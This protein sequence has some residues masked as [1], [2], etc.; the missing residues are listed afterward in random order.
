V[1]T[2][3]ASVDGTAA[4]FMVTLVVAVGLAIIPLLRASTIDLRLPGMTT[5]LV[6]T[7]F[8]TLTLLVLTHTSDLMLGSLPT[9]PLDLIRAVVIVSVPAAVAVA[10][11]MLATGRRR[12]GTTA[13]GSGV[14]ALSAGVLGLADVV[15]PIELV[16]VPLAL[17]LLAIGAV[18]LSEKAGARSWPWLAPGTAVLLV[19]SLLAIDSAGEPLWRALA[20]GVLATS[21]F[22]LSLRLKLQAP[23]VV[24]GV[25]LL[26]HLL[27]QSWPL[28]ELVGEAVEWWIWLGLAGVAVVALAAR[29]ERRLQS[30][31]N[32]A[33]RI[34][35][36]R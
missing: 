13:A 19:S 21:I 2:M 26:V 36:L 12:I 23:F 22:V 35:Q 3:L 30:A 24:S 1:P 7:G 29:Y 15:D 31:R 34:S 10:A 33:T 6:S 14:A 8:A 4:R 18:R 25:L 20:L 28:L 27:V 11:W 32:L 16:S 9:P 5:A 17:A